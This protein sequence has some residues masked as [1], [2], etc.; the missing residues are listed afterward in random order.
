MITSPASEIWGTGRPSRLHTRTPDDRKAIGV[1]VSLIAP[2]HWRCPLAPGG[3]WVNRTGVAAVRRRESARSCSSSTRPRS[4]ARPRLEDTRRSVVWPSQERG[5]RRPRRL[6]GRPRPTC[7]RPAPARARRGSA[8]R[9]AQ[10][11]ERRAVRTP[12]PALAL[13]YVG[14]AGWWPS[15][16][17]SSRRT[18]EAST[19]RRVGRRSVASRRVGRRRPR[20]KPESGRRERQR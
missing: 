6:H 12:G 5:R 3:A 9:R 15:S 16:S 18:A 20:W 19:R 1:R 4:P 7:H 17:A 10:G 13:G 14:E 2:E 11:S 8:G